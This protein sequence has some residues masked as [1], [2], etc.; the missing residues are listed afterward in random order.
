VPVCIPVLFNTADGIGCNIWGRSRLRYFQVPSWTL[1]FFRER[2]LISISLRGNL[3]IVV[4][5]V[6]NRGHCFIYYIAS[7]RLLMLMLLLAQ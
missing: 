5:T 2:A 4:S 3:A 6:P 1:F 7:F